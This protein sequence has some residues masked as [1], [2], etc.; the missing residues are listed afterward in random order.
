MAKSR[1]PK[2]LSSFDVYLRN[3]VTLL[4]AIVSGIITKGEHLG[5]KPA[6]VTSLTD[7]LTRWFTGDPANPGLWELHSNPETKGKK[8]RLNVIK[9]IKEFILFFQPLF[10]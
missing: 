7:F 9:F 1:I 4:T 3:V 8:T 10:F 2:K 6:E 5:M